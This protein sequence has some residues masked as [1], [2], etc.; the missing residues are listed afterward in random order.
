MFSEFNCRVSSVHRRHGDPYPLPRVGQP[1]AAGVLSWRLDGAVGALNQLSGAFFNRTK[2]ADIL[3]TAVQKLMMEDLRKRIP[4]Y[5]D[6][7]NNLH[8]EQSLREFLQ[9]ANLYTQEANNVA[10]FDAKEIKILSRKFEPIPAAEVASP[11]VSK[12]LDNFKNLV[13]RSV[14]KLEDIRA[15]KPLI[16][17]HWDVRLKSSKSS[18]MSLYKQLFDCGLLTF[19][20]RQKARVG[21][22][23]VKKKENKPG[24]SQQLIVDC[25]QSNALLRKSPTTRL[26]TPVNLTSMD[27]SN[28]TMDEDGFDS[29]E[30]GSFHPN[31]ETGDVGDCFYNFLVPQA[32]S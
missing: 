6:K 32:C 28:T 12:F 13:E 30:D 3:F 16:E 31:M 20:W 2:I 25:R 17:P 19:R 11:I 7:A 4:N 14:Q 8:D 1:T 23:A 24:N 29:F 26:S 21:I 15:D 27:F 22:F 18:R 5:G 10:K 9:H